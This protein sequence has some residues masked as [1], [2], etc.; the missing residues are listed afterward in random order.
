LD[1]IGE[2]IMTF[3]NLKLTRRRFMLVSAAGVAAPLLT[4]LADLAPEAGAAE[5]P[6]AAKEDNADY[7]NPECNGC[8]VCTIFYSNC[9]AVNNRLCWCEAAGERNGG[10]DKA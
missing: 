9:L 1:K 8:Q 2:D 6:K 4:S 3:E 5:E 7:S 10:N